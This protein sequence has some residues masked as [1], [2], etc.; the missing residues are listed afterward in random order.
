LKSN[1]K[2]SI[3]ILLQTNFGKKESGVTKSIPKQPG[4]RFTQPSKAPAGLTLFT[5]NF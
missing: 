2:K 4:H 1:G 5:I 3:T